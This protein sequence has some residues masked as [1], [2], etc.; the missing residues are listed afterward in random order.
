MSVSGGAAPVLAAKLSVPGGALRS[1]R[2]ALATIRCLQLVDPREAV[3]GLLEEAL[4]H[5]HRDRVGVGQV[6][7]D[8]VGGEQ[9]VERHHRVARVV[10]AEVGDRELRHVGQSSA[11]CWPG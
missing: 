1:A 6:V 7:G 11:T 10:A 3:L 8:L 5:H 4:P 9:H 2:S